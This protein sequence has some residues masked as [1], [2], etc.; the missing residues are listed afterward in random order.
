VIQVTDNK[1]NSD[2]YLWEEWE[3]KDSS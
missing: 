1:E 3:R 2:L